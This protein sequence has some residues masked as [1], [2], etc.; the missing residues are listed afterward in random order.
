MENLRTDLRNTNLPSADRVGMLAS[1]AQVNDPQ[2]P[3]MLWE[4]MKDNALRADVIRYLARY[5]QPETPEVLLEGYPT[6]S[7][8]GETA[9]FESVLASRTSY[10]LPL[11][12]A[13][14]DGTLPRTDLS[15]SLIRDL[16]NLKHDEVDHLLS[17]VWGAF[18]GHCC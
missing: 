18:P 11:L 16:R 15:A 4:L 3:A 13:M 8:P 10:A 5:Q 1:L 12:Q 2:L 9:C 14:A 17:V 7:A 6:Y